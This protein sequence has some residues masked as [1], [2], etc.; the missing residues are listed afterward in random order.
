MPVFE[1]EKEFE[2]LLME[3]SDT[4]LVDN[5]GDGSYISQV[6]LPGYGFIDI[7]GIDCRE[8]EGVYT[9]Y[10]TVI[11]LKKG[12]L[13]FNSVQQIC[14]YIQG[15]LRATKSVPKN[16][17]YA[18]KI[19]GVLIGSHIASGDV[20]FVM[21]Q[22]HHLQVKTYNIHPING[23]QFEDQSGWFNQDESLRGIK[24]IMFEHILDA[25]I[26]EKGA[27]EL[28]KKRDAGES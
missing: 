27:V 25:Y 9:F 28:Y 1:S 4:L 10:L 13:D 5:I 26:M 17:K 19:R 7:L 23:I 20:V 21:D 11:E 24:E 6:E 16:K 12:C 3:F 22:L 18:Y 15:L 8:V 2:N 14:R